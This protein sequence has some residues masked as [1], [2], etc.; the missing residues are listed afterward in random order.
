MEHKYVPNL[1]WFIIIYKLSEKKTGSF[2]EGMTETN[3]NK[4]ATQNCRPAAAP[5]WARS[6]PGAAWA[7][8]LPVKS[9]R[10]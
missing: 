6:H 1:Y 10:L 7:Q 5:C 4:S 2:K 9:L 8:V 3:K